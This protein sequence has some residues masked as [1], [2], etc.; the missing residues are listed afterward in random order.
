MLFIKKKLVAP[1]HFHKVKQN[2]NVDLDTYFLT[3][4]KRFVAI[5]M[6]YSAV[7]IYLYCSTWIYN[8]FIPK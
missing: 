1:P 6:T 5:F 4:V 2:S 7:K 3:A 8:F